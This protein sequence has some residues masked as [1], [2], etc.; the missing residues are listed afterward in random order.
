MRVWETFEVSISVSVSSLLIS[1]KFLFSRGLYR[2]PDLMNLLCLFL[3]LVLCVAAQEVVYHTE[4]EDSIFEDT[5]RE[6]C[7]VELISL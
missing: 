7:T 2:M 3:L 4:N 6:K 5:G 1:K